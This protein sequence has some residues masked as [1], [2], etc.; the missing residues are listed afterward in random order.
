[1]KHLA[2]WIALCV[3]GCWATGQVEDPVGDA[4]TPNP[5]PEPNPDPQAETD[6]GT[7][8]GPNVNAPPVAFTRTCA[9]CHVTQGTSS[10]NAP[11]L[12]AY[13]GTWS[14]M[15]AT[16]RAGGRVMP[17]FRPEQ[18]STEE[19][20]Q[21]HGYFSAGRPVATACPDPNP[22]PGT[23]EDP[24][25]SYTAL[26]SPTPQ[27]P[28]VERRPDGVIVTH[29]AGRVRQR[30]ELE[31][32]Y[33]TFGPHYFEN[34]S[35][36]F[37]IEDEVAAGRSRLKVTYRPEA[38]VST[39]G[40]GTNFRTW[41]VYGDGNVFHSN[42]GMTQLGPQLLEAEV[43]RNAR[44]Q[45]E[46]RVGD[47]FEV[48]FGIFIAGQNDGD[49]DA[50][51]GRTSYYTDTFRYRVGVGGLSPENRDPSGILGPGEEGRSGGDGTI[52]YIYAE[53][54]TYFSQMMLNMQEENVQAFLEGRR[55]FHTRF[56]DGD[57]SENG[58]PIFSEQAG[59]LGP[60]FNVTAC[61]DCHEHD[62]RGR[63]ADVG[64]PLESMV[65][66]LYGHPTFGNQLQNQEGRGVISR[67]ET[68][69]VELADGTTVELRRPVVEVP[70]QSMA[71]S[72]RIARQF[73]G[74]GLLEAI[75]EEDLLGRADPLDCNAD[76]IS[77]RPQLISE[78][79]TG[80]MRVGRYGWR[81]EK[82]SVAHQ[83]ADALEAD[84]GVTSPMMPGQEGAELGNSDFEKL[85]RYVSLTAVPPRRD[86]EDPEVQRGEQLFQ[87]LG[88]VACHVPEART[89]DRHP[90]VEVQHQTIRPYTD[91]LLHDLG[92]G[93]ADDSRGEDAQEW[94]T[95]P[96]WGIGLVET[97]SGELH[98][99]HDGRARS[100]PE[101]VLWHGG[102]AQG[103]RDRFAALSA[104]DR[105]LVVRFLGSL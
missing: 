14:Q 98:L 95:P 65:L 91:L 105:A 17:P 86:L 19:V 89:G 29:A 15:L 6:G 5:R 32:T 24:K 66:K 58:N 40:P 48:E 63:P 44:D 69:S 56:D 7:S 12:Y 73:V 96:L 43:T 22:G 72:A 77:G 100:F 53:P 1:M 99:L 49:P 45:R 11:D 35:Y 41:K 80:I 4:G 38:P 47:I 20:Q 33:N 93:L 3:A 10:N 102:E 62:G 39:Y 84:L 36:G 78:P 76:G 8:C 60:L 51:E 2:P 37:T 101:A 61:V 18:I 103:P 90:L 97:V 68:R 26:H 54:E 94:R 88:C 85:V 87:Q 59:K 92:P 81:A 46:L 67:Y 64:Q 82:V 52:P 30:H 55:L 70:G 71:F 13:R 74:M 27:R 42:G 83:V 75:A 31:G 57:H 16:V 21:I 25:W 28:I 50:I 34:R 104:A 9:G 79:G 23:C